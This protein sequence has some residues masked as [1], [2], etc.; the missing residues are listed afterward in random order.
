MYGLIVLFLLISARQYQSSLPMK[1]PVIEI[2]V[3]DGMTLITKSEIEEMLYQKGLFKDSLKREDLDIK[4]IEELLKNT[5]EI[6]K[7]DVFTKLDR[8]W[9][10]KLQLKRP[11]V[12]VIDPNNDGFYL[13]SDGKMMRLSPYYR[14]KVLPVTG[15]NTAWSNEFEFN[16][17]INNDSLI[18]KY[19]LRDLY[20]ISSYVCND[21]FYNASIVQIEFTEEMGFVLI[22]RL[23]GQ[24]IILGEGFSKEE[25]DRKFLKLTTFY[26]EVMPYEGWDAYKTIDLRFENQIVAKKN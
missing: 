6:A 17:V 12:R 11:I 20:L 19:K 2:E 15:L 26:E 5:N 25:V 10:I 9:F 22:P 8:E 18:T 13:D 24:R 1:N 4:A 16:E 7:V 14:P 21:A 23:G 3:M